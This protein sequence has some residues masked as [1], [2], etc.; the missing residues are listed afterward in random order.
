MNTFFTV[1]LIILA[2][3][4]VAFIVLF[5]VGRKAQKKQSE[6]KAQIEANK[7]VVSMLIID[8]KKLKMKD[9][10]LPQAVLD[11]TP[12]LMRRSKLPIVKAKIGPQILS[13]VCDAAIF[14]SI[15]VKKE[16][17]AV[18]SGIYI[19]EVKGLRGNITTK[20]GPAKKKSRYKKFV[21]KMQEKAGAKPL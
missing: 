20:G 2:V 10:G 21:E 19:S 15:P 11:Q 17:K 8:K 7:Q 5:F 3:V 1:L 9:S 14:D 18:I 13:L 12:K 16:V 4:L 6:Q